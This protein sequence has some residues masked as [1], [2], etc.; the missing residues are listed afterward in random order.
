MI[1]LQHFGSLLFLSGII[2]FGLMHVAIAFHSPQLTGD[3]VS[4]L[5]NAKGWIP[6]LLSIVF[7]LTGL[8][9]LLD[10][11]LDERLEKE[12]REKESESRN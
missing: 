8:F 2:L 12:D 10:G 6:Y 5:S 3:F 9:I 11:I 7:M 4:T 1:R